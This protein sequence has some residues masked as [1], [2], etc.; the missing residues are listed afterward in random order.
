[1]TQTTTLTEVAERF[2]AGFPGL[3]DAGEQRLA[4]RLFRVLAEGEPVETARLADAVGRPD[5]EVAR[6]LAG[7]VFDPLLYRD[8][9]GRIVGFGG[10][11]VGDLAQTPHRLELDGRELYAW[12]A[13][14][15]LFLPVVLEREARVE[16]RCPVTGERIVL[17]VAPEGYRDQQPA[18][19]VMSMLRPEEIEARA[20]AGGD[21]IRSFCHFIHFFAS[22]EAARAWVEEHPDTTQISIEDGFEVGRR[23]IAHLW[24]VGADR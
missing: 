4:S 12:C 13:A 16:S 22:E 20:A 18:N 8:E 1:M 10:L 9:R 19:S 2:E 3:T 14:D 24:G 15:A 17:T 23:W 21:V 6:V 11:A 5:D 7:P